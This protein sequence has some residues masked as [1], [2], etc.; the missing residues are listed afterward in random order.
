VR[1]EHINLTFDKL[2]RYRARFEEQGMASI[3]PMS[4]EGP[5]ISVL[6]Y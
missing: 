6:A 5:V 2:A 4:T 1:I 3:Y